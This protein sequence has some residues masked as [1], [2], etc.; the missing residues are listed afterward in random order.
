MNSLSRKIRLTITPDYV[1]E[2]GFWEACRELLQNSIDE[3]AVNDLAGPIFEYDRDRE[4]LRIGAT[5]CHLDRETLLL[6]NTTKRGDRG[7][8][9]QFGEGYKLAMLVLAR[10]SY[11][12]VVENGD[13]EWLVSI[14][15]DPDFNDTHVLTVGV[16]GEKSF[17]DGVVFRIN[18]VDQSHYDAI[19]E[20]Y[21]MGR[22]NNEILD[23]EHLRGKIF[24]G[25][26]YVC[27]IESLKY[28]Y[29][30]APGAVSLNRDR[31][32]LYEWEVTGVTSRLWAVSENPK[33]VYRLAMDGAADVKDL[34]DAHVYLCGDS[35]AKAKALEQAV[36]SCYREESG[37]RVPIS[38]D[39]ERRWLRG[40]AH[41]IV[42]APLRALLH[43]VSDF[44]IA[45]NTQSPGETLSAFREKWSGRM[46][47]EMLSDFSEVQRVAK[48][49]AS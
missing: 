9:G 17:R 18:D 4:T 26:L 33:Q 31:S 1:S 10:S 49:W 22:R 28:G 7:A 37:N 13:E 25:G 15:R 5:N 14:E 24:V 6:G 19:H 23:E 44:A 12:V 11:D 39:N 45:E 16:V 30:F 8:I 2:W 48:G 38:S 27:K 29:N 43:R 20:K 32:M 42:P 3:C 41:R 34:D 36:V 35:R 40:A 46:S 47:K 21:L